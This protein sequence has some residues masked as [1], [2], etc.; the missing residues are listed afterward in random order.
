MS[1]LGRNTQGVRVIKVK[2]GEHLIGVQRIEET[3]EVHSESDEDES[4]E[5]ISVVTTEGAA[6]GSSDDSPAAP[7]DDA[8]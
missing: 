5:D 4:S 3:V 7:A 6:S 2:E 8:E 1:V